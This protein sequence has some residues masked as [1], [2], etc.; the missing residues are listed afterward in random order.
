MHRSHSHS[1]SL[2]L[3]ITCM[4]LPKR[5]LAGGQ[6]VGIPGANVT[7]LCLHTGEGTYEEVQHIWACGD[8]WAW[9]CP[10]LRIRVDLRAFVDVG[11]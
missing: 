8:L 10:A 9:P 3:P 6:G 5:Q 1:S 7:G 2:Q 4:E 11:I